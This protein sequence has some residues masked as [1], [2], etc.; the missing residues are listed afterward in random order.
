MVIE[1]CGLEGLAVNE[2]TGVVDKD[3]NATG[4]LSELVDHL[5]DLI[6]IADVGAE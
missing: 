6:L 5:A 1:R 3:I 4:G 2:V